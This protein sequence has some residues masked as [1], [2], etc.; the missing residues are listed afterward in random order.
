MTSTVA[1]GP[2]SLALLPPYLG[3]VTVDESS[4]LA[5]TTMVVDAG[6]DEVDMVIDRGAFLGG[7]YGF[8]FEQIQGGQGGLRRRPAQGHP[9]DRRARHLRQRTAVSAGAR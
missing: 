6:A 2:R 5:E 3:D 9:R 8:V 1:E 7:R 4:L